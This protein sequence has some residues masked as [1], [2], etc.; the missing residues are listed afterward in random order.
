MKTRQRNGGLRKVCGCPRR[1]WAKCDHGWRVNFKW[2]GVHHRYAIDRIVG[3][4]IRSKT[5]ADTEAERIRT[6]IRAGTFCRPGAEPAAPVKETVTLAKLFE[7]FKKRYL[8]I[9]RPT[10]LTNTDYQ[11]KTIAAVELERAD[12]TRR[13][14]GQWL[15]A[16]I[17]TDTLEQFQ[18]ARRVRGVAAANR[19]LSL[20]RCMFN[21]AASNKR[22]LVASN[23]FRDGHLPAI[24]LEPEP[25][26]RRRLQPNEGEQL[27][28]ACGAHLRALVEA[29]LETGCRK[30]ELLSMQWS[31]V[32]FD[33]S[34]I[35]LPAVKTKTR[36][37]RW[38]PMSSRLKAILE[39]RRHD[40]AGEEHPAEAYVFG[41]EVGQRVKTFKRAWERA[42]LVAHGHKPEYVKRD[43]GEGRKPVKTAVLTKA[44]R[45]ALNAIDLNFHDLRREAGSRWMDAGVPLA[46]IQRWLGHT[47]VAQTSTYLA[48]TTAGEHEAMRRFEARRAE[49]VQQS[50][51][52]SRTEG[53]D[54]AQLAAT[55][56]SE[57]RLRS[58]KHH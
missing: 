5:E 44:S 30:G 38:I 3:K 41:N 21:W 32:R 29:A 39:M 4:P 9:Q 45:A 19:D 11:T 8:E 37:D 18:A 49:G 2:K 54:P 58:I 34:D 55:G 51:T 48:T 53:H 56:H 35:H 27:L 25:P 16:D 10:T 28:S 50:A 47:N 12:G 14:F 36:V 57:T 31:Q 17:T 52:D 24:K 22:Q 6:E 13:A 43:A 42:L 40:P 7:H 20:L 15:V 46:T 23:P 33:R 26:R 1:A